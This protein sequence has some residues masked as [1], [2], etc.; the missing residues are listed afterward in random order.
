MRLQAYDDN[1]TMK[2]RQVSGSQALDSLPVGTTI[3]YEGRVI[4]NGYLFCDGSTFD[5]TKY[6]ELYTL[7]GTDTLPELFDHDKRD[8]AYTNIRSEVGSTV[9]TAYEMPY[10]GDITFTG[11]GYSQSYCGVYVLKADGTTLDWSATFAGSY[12]G[13]SASGG[14][15]LF[16][17]KGDKF[18]ASANNSN[19]TLFIQ[20]RFY[21]QHLLIKAATIGIADIEINAIKDALVGIS[22]KLVWTNTN[23]TSSFGAQDIILS[24]PIIGYDFIKIEHTIMAGGRQVDTYYLES[25]GAGIQDVV[26]AS[27]PNITCSN[28][29]FSIVDDTTVHFG[30]ASSV[31]VAAQAA[32][33]VI[34]NGRTIPTRIWLC[35]QFRED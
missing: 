21:K 1:G 5:V 35:K 23:P 19:R 10:D 28:R 33:A 25:G 9:Q 8:T 30:T 18:Y 24:E 16:L 20:A 7:L 3:G 32:N 17:N 26:F 13:A 31:A 22:G 34:N 2:F 14:T 4:P 15:A 12:D 29:T 11:S 6:P 27:G